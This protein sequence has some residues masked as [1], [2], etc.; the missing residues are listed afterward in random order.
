MKCIDCQYSK[1]W[2]CPPKKLKGLIM[3]LNPSFDPPTPEV[4][5][6]QIA[7]SKFKKEENE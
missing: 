1:D 7:C 6:D 2:C 5:K 4:K 3:C